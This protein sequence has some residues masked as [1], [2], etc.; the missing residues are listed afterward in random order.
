MRSA[1]ASDDDHSVEF[2]MSSTTA[3]AFCPR[4]LSRNMIFG[5]TPTLLQDVTAIYDRYSYD[6][7]KKAALEEWSKRLMFMVSGL[8]VAQ[9][10]A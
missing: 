4:I 6:A 7:E 2:D 8:K 9:S 5:H 1:R 10:E 3:G